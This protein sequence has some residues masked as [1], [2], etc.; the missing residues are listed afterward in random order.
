MP[1]HGGDLDAAIARHGGARADWIDLSTGI[2]PV[3]WPVPE[4]A[5][6]HWA[7]LPDRGATERLEAAARA[8]WRV[9]DGA[10]VLAAPG[11]SAL[12]RQIPRLGRGGAVAIPGPTYN[13]HARA[14]A[15][16]GWRV[17]ERPEPG[18]AA[19]VI[20]NPNNPDG[21]RWT[22][23]ELMLLAEAVPL[24]VVDESFCDPFPELSVVGR[25]GAEGL[26]VLRSFGKF[27]GLAGLRLGFAITAPRT[28]E[29]LAGLL[30]PWPVSGPAL[31]I[32]A[33]ALAD[34][35]W[36]AAA[37]ARVQRGAVRLSRLGRAAG[38]RVVGEAGLFV[39]FATPDAAAAQQSLAAARIWSRIFPWSAEWIRLGLPGSERDWAR[40][41]AALACS[42]SR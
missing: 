4:L 35:A 42:P 5:A 23:D 13:E 8:F 9:P 33:R 15:A 39:T 11:A 10:A 40:L 24:L 28:A 30:G 16:E 2:A 31:E 38:W 20:V 34:G 41:E 19:A 18:I 12:I 32:G 6:E 21:R 36:A 27:W 25:A 26:V 14:F 1:D 7:R 29:R 3:A 17:V 37:R 22:P